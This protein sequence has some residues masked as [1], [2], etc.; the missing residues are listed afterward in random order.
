MEEKLSVCIP[1]YNAEPTILQT[2]NSILAQTFA[3]FE[4][5]IVDNASTDDSIK[6][7]KS[8]KDKRIKL[9]QN[10]KN[11]GCGGNLTACAQKASTDLIFYVCADDIIDIN[12]LKR[13]YDAFAISN[14]IGIVTRP[15][16]W[17]E[18]D[19]NKPVRLT[20]QFTKDEIV[21]IDG[22]YEKIKDVIALADQIS[23]IGLRKKYMEKS[24]NTHPFIE[25][26]SMVVPMLKK[27]KAVILK[28]NTVAARIT[29]SGSKSSTVYI[30][31]PMMAWYNLIDRTFSEE[32]FKGLKLYLVDN[33]IANNF[34]GLVQIKNY[35]TLK[36]LFREIYL[37]LKLKWI[38][39]FSPKF[40]FYSLGT[41]LTPRFLLQRM[42]PLYKDR[43]NSKIIQKIKFNYVT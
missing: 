8:V 13:V 35:G 30:N 9:F 23:G 34:I 15:Y 19:I 39:I 36:Q 25:M 10:E 3:D 14:N 33:F 42:V 32:R 20:K 16:F 21:S 41:I 17:Y 6:I 24:F 37:L 12:T 38:N 27:C 29:Y 18:R 4:L 40:W 28:D 43:I 1:V 31:S 7:I 11:L 2:I 22:P 5:V 26:S